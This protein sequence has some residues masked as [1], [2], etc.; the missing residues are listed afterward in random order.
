[1]QND[2]PVDK[3]EPIDGPTTPVKSEFNDQSSVDDNEQKIAA[4]KAQ[5]TNNN[6]QNK[7]PADANGSEWDTE[8]ASGLDEEELLDVIDFD[9][10][11]PNYDKMVEELVQKSMAAH[12]QKTEGDYDKNIIPEDLF[13]E[14]LTPCIVNRYEEHDDAVMSIAVD[15]RCNR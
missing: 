14:F 8:N 9:P 1:M 15:P 11:D 2:L 4:E 3:P 10:E 13:E 5:P 12:G 6:Q 7:T